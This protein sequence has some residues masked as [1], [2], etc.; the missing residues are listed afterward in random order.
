MTDW[1]EERWIKV[2]VRD[3]APWLALDWRARGLYGL[4]QRVA[5]RSGTIDLGRSGK[6]ALAVLLRADEASLSGPLLELVEAGMVE[7]VDGGLR[8]PD[9][10]A[11]QTARASDAARQ[12]AK[13]E[14]SR[15][16]T[17]S[18]A[19]SRAVTPSHDKNRID[20]NRGEREIA[21]A[22]EARVPADPKA[23]ELAKDLEANPAFASLDVAGV[24]EALIGHLGAAAFNVGPDKWRPAI[25]EAAVMVESGATEARRRQVLGWK[26]A[27]LRDG[28]RRKA[29]PAVQRDPD[30]D[31]QIKEWMNAPK[32]D[33]PAIDEF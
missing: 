33:I 17:Q 3:S 18:H 10:V 16:V 32:P 23:A 24:A 2:Y 9:H 25:A 4:L 27:D 26:F 7:E 28:R 11:Q 29:A 21:R 13:R 15:D 12:R 14:R 5:D 30:L 31:A 8:L 6:R 20:K 1:S 22:R 19:P